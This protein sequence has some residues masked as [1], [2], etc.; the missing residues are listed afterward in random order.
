MKKDPVDGV[1]LFRQFKKGNVNEFV[2]SVVFQGQPTHH[3]TKLQGGTFFVNGQKLENCT[4]LKQVCPNTTNVPD[5]M[6]FSSLARAYCDTLLFF[7]C[8][9]C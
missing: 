5:P 1:Y 9:C 6:S 4:T 3:H 8:C 7:L 2:L